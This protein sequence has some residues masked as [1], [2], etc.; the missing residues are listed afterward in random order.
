[1]LPAAIALSYSFE[2]IRND[3]S[4]KIPIIIYEKS[5]FNSLVWGSLTLVPHRRWA[6]GTCILFSVGIGEMF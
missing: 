6:T 4:Q 1:M 3:V 2:N 5:Q